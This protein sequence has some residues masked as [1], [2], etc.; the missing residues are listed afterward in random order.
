MNQNR[1]MFGRLVGGQIVVVK[2]VT[3]RF[4]TKSVAA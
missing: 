4:R 2:A 1:G 3:Q